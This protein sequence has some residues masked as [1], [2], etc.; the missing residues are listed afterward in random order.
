MQAEKADIGLAFDGD[1]DRLGVVTNTGKIIWP[2]RLLM[3]FARDVVSRNPGAD[4][5]YD[6]KCSRRLAGVISK[7]GAPDHVEN[8]TLADEGEDEGN[9]GVAGRR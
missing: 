3:L 6:V 5:L 2:D 9:R 7:P 1:G 8:R 4:V